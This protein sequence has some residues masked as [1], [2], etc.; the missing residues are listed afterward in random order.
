MGYD[1][2][3]GKY[4]AGKKELTNADTPVNFVHRDDVVRIIYEVIR[5]EKWNEL[6]NV[7]APQHPTR[8]EVYLKNVQDFGY[9]APTFAPASTDSFKV[10]KSDKLEKD[11]GYSFIF[12]DP[13]QFTYE[14]LPEN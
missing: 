1:R 2:M 5:Q 6:F 11:L 8:R 10:V 14:P 12:P 7:V 3:A 13:L 4:V 9:E